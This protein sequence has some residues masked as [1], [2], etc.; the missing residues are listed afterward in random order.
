MP[1]SGPS[2]V[3]TVPNW[4]GDPGAPR[5]ALATGTLPRAAGSPASGRTRGGR[6]THSPSSPPGARPCPPQKLGASNP[7]PAAAPAAR[8]IARRP[9]G[10]SCPP[11]AAG[12]ART[13]RR[14]AALRPPLCAR[15]RT[16][17]LAAA[18]GRRAAGA[19]RGAAPRHG[20]PPPTRQAS[21]RRWWRR[22]GVA[23][24]VGCARVSSLWPAAGWWREGGEGCGRGEG[25]PWRSREAWSPRSG[26]QGHPRELW[27]KSRGFTKPFKAC[28]PSDT[29]AAP[30]LFRALVSAQ[31]VAEALRA[32]RAGQPLQ[33]LDASWYLPKLGRDARREFEERHIPG[34][35]FFDIDQCSDR[36]SPYDHMLPG[37]EQ[38]AE[39]AGRLGVG[40]A[41]HVVV[42]DASEQGLYAAPRVWWMFRAFGHRTVSLLDGGL[43]H[44]LRQGLPLGSGK[45]H[46]AP[47]EFHA[48]LDPAFVKTYEDIKENLEARRFQVVDA[49]AAGRFQGT[50]PEPRDGIEPGHIP[51]TVNIPFTEFMTPEG[52]EKSPE[53]IQ[54]LFQE[55]KVDLSRPLVATCGSGVTACHVALGAYLC[56]KPD[57][58]IYD[59]SWVERALSRCSWLGCA[60]RGAGRARGASRRPTTCGA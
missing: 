42:Y 30:Q 25:A 57:V 29:M 44:W 33:L 55:K 24:A 27:K 4:A 20:R 45:S 56:G 32:P 9:R 12:S 7:E 26:F 52:L 11:A 60:S 49:R 19:R 36:T 50:E 47:A 10:G 6:R 51:G 22:L 48:Q 17:P 37:A 28:S 3:P 40:A 13:P 34:A 23:A 35:A 2:S 5:P 1:E 54:R 58:P 31:W 18:G 21:G 39:Y 41:T 46:P 15:R 43:R 16:D 8:T 14:R 59:G 53:E 38:F